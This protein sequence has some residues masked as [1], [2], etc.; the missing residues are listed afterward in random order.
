MIK[1]VG[2]LLGALAL[3]IG[4]Q[5]A[6]PLPVSQWN[7]ATAPGN[8]AELTEKGG[9]AFLDFEI[10]LGEMSRSGHRSFHYGYADIFLKTPQKLAPSTERIVYEQLNLSKNNQKSTEIFLRP[11]VR[12]AEGELFVFEP[13]EFPHI[14]SGGPGWGKWMTTS[15]YAGEAGAAANEVYVVEGKPGN[16]RPDGALELIGFKLTIRQY[17]NSNLPLPKDPPKPVAGRVALGEFGVIGR[18]IPYETPFAYLDGLLKE[19]GSYNVA[20]QVLNEFQSVPVGEFSRAVSFDPDDVASRRQKLE[21]PLGPD[22]NYWI[23]YQITNKDGSV[24]S[25]DYFRRQV[26]GNPDTKKPVSV[27]IDTAP[28]LGYMRINAMHP[29]RGVYEQGRPLSVAL[30]VFPKG[31]AKLDME[32]T[33]FGYRYDEALDSGTRAVEFGNA[34]FAAF[35]IVAKPQAGRDAYRLR[36]D[37][38]DNGKVVDSQTYF[39]GY[40]T[41]FSKTLDRAGAKVDRREIKR[42]PYQRTTYLEPA[43]NIKA[44]ALK[45]EAQAEAHFREFLLNSREMASSL[46]YMI[47]LVDFEVLPG[48]FDFAM[49]DRIMESAA[50]Y[51]CRVTVRLAHADEHGKN[52]YRWL[53]Y[54]RQFNYDGTIAAGHGYYGAY[55]VTDPN[56]QKLWL[57]SYRALFDRYKKHA[58]FEGYY[59][60]QPGGE[61]TVVDQP[62]MGTIVGYSPASI[63]GF[64]IFLKESDKH[65]IESLN[66]RWGTTYASWADVTVP[67]PDFRGGPDPDRRLQ[68]IDFCRFKAAL[69]TKIWIPTAVNHIRSFDDDRVTIVYGAPSAYRDLDNKLDYGHN[70]G[71]HYG[72]RLGEFI[73]AWEKGNIGW[74]TEPHHP[75]RWAAYGDPAERGWVLDWSVWVMLAQAAGGGANLHV[76]YIPNPTLE[77]IAHYGGAFAYDS[78]EKYKTI[79]S[80]M[81]KINVVA[82]PRQ[83]AVLQDPYTLYTKHRTVF[84]ARSD[85]LKRWFELLKADSVPYEELV[86]AKL[87][88]YKLIVPNLLDE[89][90]SAETLDL[91]VRAAQNGARLVIGANTG[92]YAP[93]AGPE[94]FMLLRKLGIRPPEKAYCPKGLAVDAIVLEGA[95]FL[96][97]GSTIRF[98]TFE[99][100]RA[101]LNSEEVRATFWQ[102]PYRWIPETD[103]FGYYPGHEASDGK[104]LARF[105]DGGAA[106]SLHRVDKGEVVVFW[107]TPDIGEKRLAGMMGKIAD[108]AGVEN[109]LKD[110]P[111]QYFFEAKND[112]LKRHYLL[113]YQEK[114]GTY[115]VPVFAVPQGEWFLDE[116]VGS[117]RL[118]LYSGAEL[119]KNGL[120]LTW[121]EGYSPLK[122]IRMISSK[123]I[124][125]PW[126]DK[127]RTP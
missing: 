23:Q 26:L 68:W 110:A 21:I 77:K 79:L 100:F 115:T 27:S 66:K 2:S 56:T 71:N 116:M 94:T 106:V 45:S 120:S 46:T 123:T 10:K 107:G 111:L 102:Y 5:G 7:V 4:T 17:I 105:A 13:K 117:Q 18:L 95:P 42:F 119:R 96:K 90:I 14:Q 65:T 59:I 83:A 33:L 86:P 34:P 24:V 50:D 36:I 49:L 126:K 53:K 40:K 29:G 55:A 19:K 61:W 60:M 127:Y 92:K 52:L 112:S 108:W 87:G 109:P 89:V 44:T 39:L 82:P 22:D 101:Q 48:V 16:A 98:Q 1:Y 122:I 25:A 103:Y 99:S 64:R 11:V 125:A 76:Y 73:D 121:T 91:Y 20:I 28:A 38:K 67:M 37:L 81:H 124:G 84:R 31:K 12:D 47:D 43:K 114:P 63:A 70:G 32:W 6:S 62:W 118:G 104:V 85:D 57:A 9:A 97:A 75:H 93:E 58:A 54:S 35:D 69:S 15:F 41:D 113:A 30:R 80:E 51:G 78:F 72:E 88:T 74:I 3:A 8:R